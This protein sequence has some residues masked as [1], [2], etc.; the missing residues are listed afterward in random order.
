M[1]L[2]Q[3]EKIKKRI[4]RRRSQTSRG[5]V[6]KSGAVSIGMGP[7]TV[8]GAGEV[9]CVAEVGLVGGRSILAIDESIAVS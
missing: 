4:Q 9:E 6:E 8:A 2:V 5:I 7:L 1:F 3:E